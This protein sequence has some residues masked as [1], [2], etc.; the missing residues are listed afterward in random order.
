MLLGFTDF[1]LLIVPVIKDG[2]VCLLVLLYFNHLILKEVF[3]AF[4]GNLR[5]TFSMIYMAELVELKI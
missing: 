4:L 2:S 3:V 5:T 1:L